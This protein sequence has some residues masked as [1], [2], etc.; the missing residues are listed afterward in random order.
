MLRD[1]KS[2]TK[3]VVDYNQSPD[4]QNLREKKEKKRIPKKVFIGVGI[5]IAIVIILTTVLLLNKSVQKEEQL[6]FAFEFVRHGA[7]AP[8]AYADD[9]PVA[10]EMLTTQGMRQRYLLGKYNQ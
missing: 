1:A 3:I 10:T 4:T 7:R 5:I 6:L 8:L 2:Q 9:F